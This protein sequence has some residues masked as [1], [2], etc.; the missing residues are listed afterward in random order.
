MVWNFSKMDSASSEI[1]QEIEKCNHKCNI[2]RIYQAIKGPQCLMFIL[3]MI[4]FIRR[5][6]TLKIIL[7][8]SW[9]VAPKLS[10]IV[11]KSGW[12]L[13]SIVL[14]VANSVLNFNVKWNFL[15]QIFLCIKTVNKICHYWICT[16]ISCSLVLIMLI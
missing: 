1:F 14:N 7:I 10:T 6:I 9:I 8:L 13:V 2:F 15:R 3:P 16:S 11:L 12:Y 4:C 5:N